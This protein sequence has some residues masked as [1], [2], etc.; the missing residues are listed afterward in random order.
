MLT[1]GQPL[2][3]DAEQ[4]LQA[5]FRAVLDLGDEVDVTSVR[6]PSEPSWD[7]LAH[8]SLVAALESEFAVSIDT[9]DSIHLTSYQAAKLFLESGTGA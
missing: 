7:S 2:S 4:K 3:S 8:V 9:G 6:Q 1:Q 5:I